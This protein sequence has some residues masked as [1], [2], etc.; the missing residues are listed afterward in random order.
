MIFDD[1]QLWNLS[2]KTK[3]VLLHNVTTSK[4]TSS[5]FEIRLQSD[6]KLQAQNPIEISIPCRK[7][8]T[9]LL[10]QL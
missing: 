6:I 10:E 1:T 4:K 8:L 2:W 3:I 7:K 9:A 5:P